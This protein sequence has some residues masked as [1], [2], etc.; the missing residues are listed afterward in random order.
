MSK[1][2][3]SPNVVYTDLDLNQ[4]SRKNQMNDF[5]SQIVNLKIIGDVLVLRRCYQCS[6]ETVGT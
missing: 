6:G 1:I 2:C 5:N 4:K 3:D